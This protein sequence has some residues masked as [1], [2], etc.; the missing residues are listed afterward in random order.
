M[1]KKIIVIQL[2]LQSLQGNYQYL[3]KESRG[4]VIFYCPFNYKPNKRSMTNKVI[5]IEY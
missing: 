3:G 1:Q 2:A 5:T 4:T